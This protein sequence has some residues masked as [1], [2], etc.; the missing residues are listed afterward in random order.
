MSAALCNNIQGQAGTSTAVS[1]TFVLY[2]S[3][4]DST[5]MVHSS[6]NSSKC[7]LDESCHAQQALLRSCFTVWCG[8]TFLQVVINFLV[9]VINTHVTTMI[10][11]SQLTRNAALGPS[12]CQYI[13]ICV[14]MLGQT[15]LEYLYI[16][17]S[18]CCAPAQPWPVWRFPYKACLNE[19]KRPGL[20]CCC[21]P[22]G[23][24]YLQEGKSLGD[25]SAESPQAP[26]SETELKPYI[27]TSALRDL[28]VLKG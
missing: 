24:K 6:S 2:L 3:S 12:S 10:V 22:L 16:Y 27:F 21:E 20:G 11:P 17:Y 28:T 8:V 23:A 26:H 9:A 19:L 7:E 18:Y 25:S 13:N 15:A 1:C 14:D 5:D 4:V